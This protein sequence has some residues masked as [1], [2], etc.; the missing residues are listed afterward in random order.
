MTP[1]Y[2]EAE[3]KFRAA[4]TIQ[5]KLEA[6]EEMMAVI[7]KH[8]GTEKMRADI[9]RR[10]AKL[11]Q[12]DKSAKTG[13]RGLEVHIEKEG[14]GQVVISGPPNSGKSLLISRLTAAEPE[15]A[16]YPFTTRRPLPGMMEYED[17]LVQL[18]DM[19]PFMEGLTEPW[20]LA[21]ARNADAVVVVLDFVGG[22]ILD[23]MELVQKELARIKVRLIAPNIEPGEVYPVGTVF[24][25]ALIAANKIDMPGARENLAIFEELYGTELPILPISAMTGE[26]LEEFKTQVY[27]L[28]GVIRV[29]TK[30]PGK[31]PDMDRPFVLKKGSNVA[32]LAS[33]VH[34]EFVN[35]LR[36]ARGWG[37]NKPDGVMVGRDQELEDKDI[38]ELHV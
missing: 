36:F 10:M 4:E 2:L 31:P 13:K 18:I 21:L 29:Y 7:P 20:V 38:I 12:Q 27:N 14:A 23:D 37:K 22:N 1:Q 35:K 16:D 17:V 32:D 19:P 24:R 28:L 15:V 34:K 30:I 6:L 8:K 9:K 26:C 25:P 33:V 5:E 11:R 3:A